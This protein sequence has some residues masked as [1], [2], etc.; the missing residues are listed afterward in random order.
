[1]ASTHTTP[2]AARTAAT[3]PLIL[4]G[5]RIVDAKPGFEEM[6]SLKA[7][8]MSLAVFGQAPGFASD[9]DK[10]VQF[11]K[12]SHRINEVARVE[13]IYEQVPVPDKAACGTLAQ[14]IAQEKLAGLPY[15]WNVINWDTRMYCCPVLVLWVSTAGALPG[16]QQP[17]RRGQT[18]LPDV[19]ER[20]VGAS[21]R[22][23][24]VRGDLSAGRADA[25][26][27]DRHLENCRCGPCRSVPVVAVG[28]DF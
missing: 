11:F 27:E 26:D 16:M 24:C 22:K 14:R 2:D 13:T 18:R 10:I 25:G 4:V 8:G 15:R 6:F 5:P 3:S 7:R 19:R 12:K 1:M 9:A 17:D 28:C 23:P 21:V 20:Q